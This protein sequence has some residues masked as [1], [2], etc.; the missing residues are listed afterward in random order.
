MYTI[1]KW[2]ETRTRDKRNG[3]FQA[4]HMRRLKQLST[5]LH[6]SLNKTSIDSSAINQRQGQERASVTLLHFS[7]YLIS[8]QNTRMGTLYLVKVVIATYFFLP[9]SAIMGHAKFYRSFKVKWVNFNVVNYFTAAI[10]ILRAIIPKE[11]SSP[12]LWI[13]LA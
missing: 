8:A 1:C 6:S 2:Q 9:S 10:L 4:C 3:T 12:S 7:Y 5:V 13:P 11:D